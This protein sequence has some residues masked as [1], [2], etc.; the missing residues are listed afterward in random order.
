MS[1]SDSLR[2]AAA[3]GNIDAFYALIQKDPYML[4]LIYHIPFIHTPLHIAANEGQIKLAMEMT[5]LKPSF[6]RKLSQD[7]F[8]PMHL[9]FRNACPECIEDVTVRDET[10][11]HL[12]LKNDHIEAFNLLT[13][14]LQSNHRRGAN[15]LEKKVI[16]WSD[17]DGNTVLHIAAI[18]EQHPV[19]GGHDQRNVGGCDASYNSSLPIIF[20]PTERC[21]ARFK[22]LLGEET[23]KSGTTVMNP[24]MYYGFWVYN[25]I[26]YGLPVLLRVFLLSHVPHV[27]LIPLYYLSVS[28]FYSMTII[29]PSSFWVDV[30][31]ILANV[32]A[33]FRSP[34]LMDV[35]QLQ[36]I[37]TIT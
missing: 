4:E 10:A 34:P 22:H 20:K 28:Y 24:D 30:N 9:A 25:L 26:A 14:W 3:T 17:D 12:A 6:A 15:E 19:V 29:S 27:L 18:K 21:L 31:Y 35:T 23:R 11:L 33:A 7:G 32:I 2:E 5:N 13:G 8:S 1:M 36:G 37:Q 16:K